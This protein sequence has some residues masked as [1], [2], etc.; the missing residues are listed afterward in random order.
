MG[1]QVDAIVDQDGPKAASRLEEI[2]R[3]FEVWE[4]RLSRFRP[5]SEL[6]HLNRHPDQEVPVS[7]VM[8][9][10]LR[11]AIRA[12]HESGGLV[13]PTLL[14]ELERAGYDHSLDQ[15]SSE[16]RDEK[17][18]PGNPPEATQ[19]PPVILVKKNGRLV[20][21]GPKTRLDLGGIA[22]GW[23]ADRAARRL[24]KSGP[25]LV[26]A[27]GDISVSGPL[28]DGSPWPVGVCDPWHPD[29]HL[30]IIGLTRGGVATS[31]KDRRRWLKNGAWQ[32]HLIDPAT[33][34]PAYTD[35]MTAS[36]IAPSAQTAEM[37]AKTVFLSGSLRG[38]EWLE[39]RLELAGLVVLENGE[40][41]QSRRWQN[42]VLR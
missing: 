31:G 24:S 10:V 13:T 20:R 28:A 38:L 4:E 5:T 42:Y 29:Q 21:L 35:I 36:V 33:G 19:E 12:Q 9:E 39:G 34:N 23:A 25:A 15:I 1:C 27:G 41:L 6:S 32:H 17:I 3:W 18:M 37:A 30:Q 16:I 7:P 40:V 26:D 22:K 8:A 2:P 11:A 14:A